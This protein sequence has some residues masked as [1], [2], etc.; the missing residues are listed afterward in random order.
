MR[1]QPSSRS[2]QDSSASELPLWAAISSA[3][4]SAS[5]RGWTSPG[6]LTLLALLSAGV[7][8]ASGTGRRNLFALAVLALAAYG[9][10]AAGRAIL[11]EGAHMPY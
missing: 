10:I 4:T 2:S 9:M 11:F 7:A 3:R 5:H 8:C 1:C 6:G